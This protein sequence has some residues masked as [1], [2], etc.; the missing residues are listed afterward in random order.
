MK[1]EDQVCSLEQAKRLKELGVKQEG[2]FNYLKTGGLKLSSEFP[3][4]LHCYSAFTVAE[5]G[6]MIFKTK[7]WNWQRRILTF[8]SQESGKCSSS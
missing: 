8:S 2:I 5:L 4:F 7:T 3:S 1:L 6:E